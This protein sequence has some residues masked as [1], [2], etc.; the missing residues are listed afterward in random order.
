MKNYF[1]KK[2]EMYLNKHLFLYF[3]C[4]PY[5]SGVHLWPPTNKPEMHMCLFLKKI[6]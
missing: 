2:K 4:K 1:K 5:N 6:E 3:F